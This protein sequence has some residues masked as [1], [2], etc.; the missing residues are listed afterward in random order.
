MNRRLILAMIALLP[1]LGSQAALAAEKSPFNVPDSL[2]LSQAPAGAI[3][4][5]RLEPVI[6]LET[7]T[8][9]VDIVDDSLKYHSVMDPSMAMPM[10]LNGNAQMNRPLVGAGIYQ[11]PQQASPTPMQAVSSPVATTSPVS[12]AQAA[13]PGSGPSFTQKLSQS[14]WQQVPTISPVPMVPMTPYMQPAYM[15]SPYMPAPVVQVDTK[16]AIGLIGATA[17][18]GAFVQNGGVGGLMKSLGMDNQRH[19]RGNGGF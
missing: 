9:G 17:L 19:I 15:P 12:T 2:A 11:I 5:G 16:R 3:E 13:S 6:P 4:S 8:T 7:S 18:M 1:W 14:L 10:T